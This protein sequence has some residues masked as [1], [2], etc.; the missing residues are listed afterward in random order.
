M[1]KTVVTTYLQMTHPDQFRP[2]KGF[3]EKIQVKKIANDPFINFMLFAGVGLPYRWSSRFKFSVDQWR[4]YFLTKNL[5]TYIGFIDNKII[6]YFELM[7]EKDNTEIIFFGMFPEFTGTGLGGFF[8]SHAIRC[9]WETGAKRIWLHTCTSDN[10]NALPNY[11][12]RG[13]KIF[14]EKSKSENVPE[15]DEL[16]EKISVFF[17]DYLAKYGTVLISD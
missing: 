9:A 16:I 13:F 8:L 3:D 5:K 7:V 10:K 4:D 2:K 15:P 11:L 1:Q 14:D 12:A 6:G 17:S